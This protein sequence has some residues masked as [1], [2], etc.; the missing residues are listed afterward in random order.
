MGKPKTACLNGYR[1]G[2]DVGRRQVHPRFRLVPSEASTFPQGVGTTRF[3]LAAALTLAL[4]GSAA[5]ASI[6]PGYYIPAGFHRARTLEQP[7]SWVAKRP[8]L[9]YCAESN[10]AWAAHV[11]QLG[12]LAGD[13]FLRG[14]IELFQ[15]G[16]CLH[17]GARAEGRSV[18][19]YAFAA[20]LLTLIQASETASGVHDVE[21]C[22]A[23]ARFPDVARRFFGYRFHTQ[24][25][26][27]LAAQAFRAR[28]ALFQ[29][30]C[31]HAGS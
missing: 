6:P 21:G 14:G 13:A 12:P 19:R 11:Q 30:S 17:A 29:G 5:A 24:P 15:R 23:L 22:L 25:L 9:V 28:R 27:L 2:E 8:V 18:D 20:A 10:S 3:V 4:A 1:F 7:A 31:P 16:V 26:R